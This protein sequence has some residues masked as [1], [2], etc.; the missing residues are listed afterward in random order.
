[1]RK[2]CEF[3]I[4]R[5]C[6]AGGGRTYTGFDRLG[7]EAIGMCPTRW[8]AFMWTSTEI[9]LASSFFYSQAL[10]TPT[11]SPVTQTVSPSPHYRHCLRP[12]ALLSVLI[13]GHP[14]PDSHIKVTML[15]PLFFNSEQ[16][17]VSDQNYSDH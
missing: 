9:F 14:F 4:R 3:I 6:R 10:S 13:A 1:M 7:F 2:T 11:S 16:F 5:F 17:L 15:L 8:C 12:V